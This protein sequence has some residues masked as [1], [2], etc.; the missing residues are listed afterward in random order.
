MNRPNLTL[1]LCFTF[2]LIIAAHINAQDL[3][4]VFGAKGGARSSQR[5]SGTW[6]NQ[7]Q[8]LTLDHEQ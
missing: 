5:L 6:A 1:A 4:R 3:S 2:G 8:P 7:D